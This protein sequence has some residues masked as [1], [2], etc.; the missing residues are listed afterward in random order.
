MVHDLQ[1]DARIT[2]VKL[3]TGSCIY[4][5]TAPAHDQDPSAVDLVH[6]LPLLYIAWQNQSPPPLTQNPCK[7]NQKNQKTIEN[8]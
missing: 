2:V 6:G 4:I 8:G 5:P 1:S 3:A 7:V